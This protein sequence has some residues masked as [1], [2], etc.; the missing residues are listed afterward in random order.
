[1]A[2]IVQLPGAAPVSVGTGTTNALQL[3]GYTVNGCEITS[4][5]MMDRRAWR[6]GRWRRRNPH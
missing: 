3:L 4:E 5:K 1:M 6:S 2:A